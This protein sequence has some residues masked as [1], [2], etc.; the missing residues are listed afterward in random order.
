MQLMVKDGR[1]LFFLDSMPIRIDEPSR[2]RHDPVPTAQAGNSILL[3]PLQNQ[4]RAAASL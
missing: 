4:I 3:A 1:N 2:S